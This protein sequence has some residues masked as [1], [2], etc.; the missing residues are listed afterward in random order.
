VLARPE[1]LHYRHTGEEN[2]KKNVR[3]IADFLPL[4]IAPPKKGQVRQGA[5]SD[6]R[7]NFNVSPPDVRP[8]AKDFFRDECSV[9]A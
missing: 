9:E 4:A 7:A 6:T 5:G 2:G 1:R 8:A 3:E